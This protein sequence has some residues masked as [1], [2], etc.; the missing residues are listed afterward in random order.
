[1]LNFSL[2]SLFC[3]SMTWRMLSFYNLFLRRFGRA[4][5]KKVVLTDRFRILLALSLIPLIYPFKLKHF[6]PWEMSHHLLQLW[7]PLG[8]WTYLTPFPTLHS[9]H[10]VK[11]PLV[12]GSFFTVCLSFDFFIPC[13]LPA[14]KSMTWNIEIKTSPV[15]S[16]LSSFSVIEARLVCHPLPVFFWGSLSYLLLNKVWFPLA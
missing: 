10:L 8:I 9:S 4:R 3:L 6:P 13:P 1:M 11:S 14:L 7:V 2:H 5:S 12:S 15:L 16:W